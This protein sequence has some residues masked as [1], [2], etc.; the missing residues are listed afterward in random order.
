MRSRRALRAE[1]ARLAAEVASLR[2]AVADLGRRLA[3]GQQSALADTVRM[4][5][6]RSQAPS[7]WP[8]E[9]WRPR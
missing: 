5:R 2:L 3:A 9:G 7:S 8:P 6:V 1:N 4:P